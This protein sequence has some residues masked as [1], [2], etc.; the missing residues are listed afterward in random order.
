MEMQ[1]ASLNCIARLSFDVN[2][3]KKEGFHTD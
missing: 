1:I 3:G 2:G